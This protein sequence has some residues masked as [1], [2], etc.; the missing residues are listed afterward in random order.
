[1]EK[2]HSFCSEI[3]S[4]NYTDS[5]GLIYQF[6]LSHLKFHG[7]VELRLSDSR[8]SIPSIIQNDVQKLLKQVIPN[9]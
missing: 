9:C 7:T 1:M 8:L 4:Y 5:W 3:P 6:A 2:L